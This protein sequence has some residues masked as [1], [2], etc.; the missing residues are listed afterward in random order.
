MNNIDT[1]IFKEDENGKFLAT[2]YSQIEVFLSCK[3]KWFKEYLLGQRK[4]STSEALSLGSAIHE[5]L[6]SVAGII[7]EHNKVEVAEAIEILDDNI[8]KH[9]IPFEN[10]QVEKEAIEQHTNMI[11]ELCEENNNLSKLLFENEIVGM[12]VPFKYKVELPFV[13]EWDNKQYKEIYIVGAIDLILKDKQGN[14]IVVDYKSGKKTFDNNKL[15]KNLQH[16]IYSLVV[17]DLYGSYPKRCLYYFTRFDIIQE[18]DK[19]LED[20]E[21][22]NKVFFAR[23]KNKGELKYQQKSPNEIIKD[24]QD[25]FKEQ[26]LVTK[27]TVEKQYPSN[28]TPLCS[29]CNFG[30][31]GDKT[32]HYRQNYIRKDIQLKE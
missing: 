16:R 25:I 18:V 32:C 26:Y 3:F 19:L 31:Y 9:K 7:V 4:P 1:K 5:T 21:I 27:E 17:K 28:P 30:L 22:P 13:F 20:G 10:K 24:L 15:Q 14:Y 6:E 12:E 29:W 2:S 23:G 8:V 11:C